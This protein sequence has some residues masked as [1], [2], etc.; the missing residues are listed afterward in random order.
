[1]GTLILDFDSTLITCESLEEIFKEKKL[2]SNALERIHNLTNQGMS[3]TLNFSFSLKSR[4]AIQPL[5]RSDFIAFGNN[6]ENFLTPGFEILIKEL[7]EIGVDIWIVSGAIRETLLPLGKQL[8]IDE[9]K[10]LGVQLDWSA[11][12][13]FAG[14]NETIAMNRSKWEGV[15]E[16]A[17]LWTSPI[18]AVGDGMTDYALYEHKVVEKFIAFTKNVR[19]PAL[20]SKTVTEAETVDQLKK[21]LISVFHAK[22][23]IS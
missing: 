22:S 14:L 23:V 5:Y 17:N 4:L 18:V 6:A 10:I 13:E 3:G 19:R 11:E 2:D 7:K 21:L 1:M 12:G 9:K 15:R 20:L 16:I 8:G